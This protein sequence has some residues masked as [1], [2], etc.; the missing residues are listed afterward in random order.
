MKMINKKCI[1]N[2]VIYYKD[3]NVN[4]LQQMH[5]SSEVGVSAGGDNTDPMFLAEAVV[6][7]SQWFICD[8]GIQVLHRG[9]GH[10]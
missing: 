3:R 2:A 4:D 5:L 9:E 1:C 8:Y 10:K 7:F 6:F